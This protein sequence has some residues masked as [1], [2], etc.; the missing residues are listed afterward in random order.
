[1]SLEWCPIVRSPS[2][3][4]YFKR[5][6]DRFATCSYTK[7]FVICVDPEVIIRQPVYYKTIS[8]GGLI[9]RISKQVAER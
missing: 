1:M 4:F 3:Q 6:P 5:R 9:M 8:V 2:F 7:I